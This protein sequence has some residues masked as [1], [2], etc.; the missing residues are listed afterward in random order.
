VV[1][2]NAAL[3]DRVRRLRVHGASGP[4]VHEEPGR[5]SRLDAVQAAVLLVKAAHLVSWHAARERLAARYVAE[6][7]RFPIVLPVPPPPPQAHAWN[8]F[9]VRTSR[10]D[11][12]AKW[13]REQGVETRAY[14]PVPLHRQPCFA[15]LAE[16]PLPVAEDACR[17]ALALPVFPAMTDDQQAHVIDCIA[18]FFR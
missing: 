11:D 17:T 12:L 2:S 13:L 3:A 10:R 5:N 18:K 7:P 16:P 8:A 9:V 14:Y 4:Y 6:L 1:T 15:P